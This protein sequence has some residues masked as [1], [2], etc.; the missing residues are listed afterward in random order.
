MIARDDWRVEEGGEYL[1]PA[2]SL[3]YDA[4]MEAVF[5]RSHSPVATAATPPHGLLLLWR[6]GE[7]SSN[8]RQRSQG[9]AFLSYI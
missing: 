3:I 1:S 5:P 8:I 6:L 4:S 7:T 2:V 9:K